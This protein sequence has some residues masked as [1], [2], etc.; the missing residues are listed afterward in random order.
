MLDC[1][2]VSSVRSPWPRGPGT[3]L[4]LMPWPA[5]QL[6]SESSDRRFRPKY[7]RA[8]GDSVAQGSKGPGMTPT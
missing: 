4:T 8:A 6:G 2:S 7:S 5:R 3:L 1:E